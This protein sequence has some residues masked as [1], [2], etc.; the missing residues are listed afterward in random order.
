MC[1]SDLVP[2]RW[3]S[4][5]ALTSQTYSTNSDIWAFGITMWEI[6]N[7]AQLPY[8]TTTY[9]KQ[10]EKI[11]SGESLELDQPVAASDKM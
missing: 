1:S 6:H 11:L 2:W 7:L 5:E 10:M 9:N 3:C 8:A 4:P